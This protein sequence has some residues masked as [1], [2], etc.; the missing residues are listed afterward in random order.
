MPTSE[1]STRFRRPTVP[2]AIN[3]KNLWKA[4]KNIL[5]AA[6]YIVIFLL[7]NSFVFPQISSFLKGQPLSTLLTDSVTAFFVFSVLSALTSGTILQLPFSFARALVPIAFTVLAYENRVLTVNL[8]EIASSG[9]ITFSIDIG[10]LLIF[11]L[12][13]DLVLLAREILQILSFLNK[14]VV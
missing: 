8:G 11:S 13:L 7:I 1:L 12:L 4:V 6:A 9:S 14:R 2:S 10:T 3:R 5:K